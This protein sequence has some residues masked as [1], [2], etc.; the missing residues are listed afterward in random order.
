[1]PVMDGIEFLRR[2][3]TEFGPDHPPVV[4][5]TAEAEIERMS[6]AFDA[7]AQEYIMKPFNEDILRDK[8][9]QAGLLQ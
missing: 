6:E 7:G 8:L 2:A 1:M 4:F 5:C 3:R 9:R